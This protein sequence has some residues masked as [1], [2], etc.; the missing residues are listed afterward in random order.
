MAAAGG[1]VL[2]KEEVH[3]LSIHAVC[4]IPGSTLER[5]SLA[6]PAGALPRSAG[7]NRACDLRNRLTALSRKVNHLT[8][9]LDKMPQDSVK[10]AKEVEA[11]VTRYV[12]Q[13]K[14]TCRR[15]NSLCRVA[16]L[17]RGRL[18]DQAR[19]KQIQDDGTTLMKQALCRH[20]H[21]ALCS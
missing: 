18:A 9:T 14:M 7:S 11:L 15:Q 1:A 12:L 5:D 10:Q 21:C 8:A 20:A 2:L 3:K 13:Q 19:I 16:W 17:E 6:P 4:Q